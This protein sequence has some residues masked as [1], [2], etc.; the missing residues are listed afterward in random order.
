MATVTWVLFA[1]HVFSHKN[2]VS[3]RVNHNFESSCLDWVSHLFSVF[4][5]FTDSKKKFKK[6]VC[7]CGRYMFYEEMKDLMPWVR[8]FYGYSGVIFL[9]ANS[10]FGQRPTVYS[11]RFSS[12]MESLNVRCL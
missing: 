6:M 4:A 8:R 9:V 5:D 11:C 2:P 1:A 10:L 12:A 7:V 3:L